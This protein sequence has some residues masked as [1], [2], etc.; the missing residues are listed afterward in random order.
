[1]TELLKRYGPWA[2]IAGASE[3]IGEAFARVLAEAGF[4]LALIARRQ[5]PLDALA[6]EL[7]ARF[8]VQVE[9]RAL[10]LAASDLEQQLSTLASQREIG[11]VVYNAA[12][13]IIAPFLETPLADKQRILDVNARGPLI[14]ADVFGRR[15]AERGR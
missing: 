13:S 14:A 4:H 11:L 2:C 9:V 15:M 3:G 7:R 1:M 8:H 12:L 5:P 6:N 10:D